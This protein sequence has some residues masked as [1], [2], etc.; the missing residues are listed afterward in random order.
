MSTP[1][2]PRLAL[3]FVAALALT[4]GGCMSSGLSA[5]E[6]RARAADERALAANHE[7]HYDESARAVHLET[8]AGDVALAPAEYNPTHFEHEAALG[9]TAAAQRHLDAAHALEVSEDAACQ[10]ISPAAREA[11][12]LL[13]PIMVDDV[14]QG[15]RVTFDSEE[16]ATRAAGVIRCEQAFAVT[17]AFAD[18]PSCALYGRGLQ[19]SQSGATVELTARVDADIIRLRANV[20]GHHHAS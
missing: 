20:R 7:A 15:V 9:H 13:A 18:L 14:K 17:R 2:R 11:C 16:H 19:V 3:V 5:A 4:G 10:G 1:Q 6:H 12:P 8:P